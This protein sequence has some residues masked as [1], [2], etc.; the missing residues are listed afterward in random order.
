MISLD[1]L[2]Q[3]GVVEPLGRQAG[4][5]AVV[6][7]DL[8]THQTKTMCNDKKRGRK[9]EM[10]HIVKQVYVLATSYCNLPIS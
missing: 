7:M 6:K 8:L 9:K 1:K 2:L 4:R 10:L 5:H 3:Q